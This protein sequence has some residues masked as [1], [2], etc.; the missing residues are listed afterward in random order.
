MIQKIKLIMN[1]HPLKSQCVLLKIFD[2]KDYRLDY[3][4]WELTSE[5][6]VEALTSEAIR[7][8]Q[9]VEFSY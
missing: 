9:C 1:Q 8:N 7:N 2:L 5:W 3:N 4:L 6:I